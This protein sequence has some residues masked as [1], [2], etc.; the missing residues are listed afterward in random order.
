MQV[1]FISDRVT[2]LIESA[3]VFHEPLP[4]GRSPFNVFTVARPLLGLPRETVGL[5]GF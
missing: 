5:E 3:L 2:E 4:L 1:P